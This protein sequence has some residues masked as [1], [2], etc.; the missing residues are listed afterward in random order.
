MIK[1]DS[2]DC[3]SS[4]TVALLH[5]AASSVSESPPLTDRA[6]PAVSFVTVSASTVDILPLIAE[7]VTAASSVS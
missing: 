4:S 1:M 2:T 3:T 7:A 5:H 6:L